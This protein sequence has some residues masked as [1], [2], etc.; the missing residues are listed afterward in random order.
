MSKTKEPSVRGGL[1]AIAPEVLQQLLQ[2]PDTVQITGVRMQPTVHGIEH[3]TIEVVLRGEPMPK[4]RQGERLPEVQAQ[5][6]T[7]EREGIRAATFE[8]FKVWNEK[9]GAWVVLGD[10]S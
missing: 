1:M 2:L 9:R 3:Q 6:A 5:Y 7:T 4:V 10:G 8:K